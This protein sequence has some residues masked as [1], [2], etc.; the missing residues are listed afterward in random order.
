MIEEEGLETEE[1][2][3]PLVIEE[4]SKT[5]PMIMEIVLHVVTLGINPEDASIVERRD[6]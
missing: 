4:D 5:D 2:E 3:D 6:I 1:E